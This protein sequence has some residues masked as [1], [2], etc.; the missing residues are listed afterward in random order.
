MSNRTIMYDDLRYIKFHWKILNNSLLLYKTIKQNLYCYKRGFI[1]IRSIWHVISKISL[2]NNISLIIQEFMNFL[3]FIKYLFWMW[4]IYRNNLR[5]F[6]RR[7]IFQE[8]TLETARERFGK[9]SRRS[10]DQKSKEKNENRGCYERGSTVRR[11]FNVLVLNGRHPGSPGGSRAS[12][13]ETSCSLTRA[14]SRSLSF[15]KDDRGT[16][17]RPMNENIYT[18]TS[19]GSFELLRLE[20]NFRHETPSFSSRVVTISCCSSPIEQANRQKMKRCRYIVEK[21]SMKETWTDAV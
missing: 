21:H 8:R 17:T 3:I 20:R 6:S 13:V 2:Y 19:R 14:R 9:T 15:T 5:E 16:E 7:I 11:G 18:Y 4:T 10:S 12:A 1:S